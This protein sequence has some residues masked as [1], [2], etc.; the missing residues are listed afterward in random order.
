MA[1]KYRLPSE[2]VTELQAAQRALH[3]ILDEFTTAEECGVDCTEYRRLQRE[4]HD[5]ISKILANYGPAVS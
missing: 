2:K 5:R 1:T 4:A 3:D